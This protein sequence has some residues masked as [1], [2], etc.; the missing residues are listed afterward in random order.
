MSHYHT[1]KVWK[2]GLFALNNTATNLYFFAMMFVSYY[3]TGVAGL[4]VVIIST[5]ITAMRV[6]DGFTDPII[7]F[8]LD[9]TES[10]FGKFRP[11]MI[12]GNAILAASLLT[13][14]NVTHLLPEALQ[15]IFFIAIY[16]IYIIGYTFQTAVTKAAQ[17][18]LTND[19]KQRPLFSI[20]DATYNTLLFVGGQILIASYLVPKYGGFNMGLFTEFNTYIIVASAL[21][22]V[23][24]V[25]GIGEKDRKEFFGLGERTVRTQFRDYWPILKGNRPMQMLVIAASTDKLAASVKQQPAVPIMFFGI[26]IGDYALSGTVSLITIIPTLVISY[27]GLGMARQIGLKRSFVGGTWLSLIT[28]SALAVFILMIDP[29]TISLSNLGVVTV[30][31]LVLYSLN[32]GFTQLTT[33][34]VIPMI[35]DCA[36]YETYQ[37]GRFIPGMLGTVFSFVDKLISS[38]SATLVGV[39]LAWIGFREV[40]P[41]VG[42]PLTSPLLVMT[43]VLF[44]GIPMFGWIASL[45]SMKFYALDNKKM[46]EIQAAI[47]EKKNKENESD[48][49]SSVLTA[50]GTEKGI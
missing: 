6:F 4:S 13:I 7:G 21:F 30:V 1:S 40:F 3:A 47:A 25:I 42:D 48:L 44:F 22:T 23:L 38:L 15:L 16:S 12:L 31:F 20:F 39:L 43:F 35:A 29:T 28:A 46:A 41:Q 26:L 37:T 32:M 14:Y 5:V 49:N 8:L 18:V 17:T 19:P 50:T 45:I 24:A 2:I 10:K 11:F 27:I 33:N 36:D 9:K 34:M